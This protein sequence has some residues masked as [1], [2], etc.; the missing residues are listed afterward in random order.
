M[1]FVDSILYR[2][3]TKAD[4][5]NIEW[6]K[7]PSGGG[8]QTYIDLS[9]VD[10]EVIK[11]FFIDTAAEIDEEATKVD[12]EG[13]EWPAYKVPIRPL[14]HSEKEFINLDVRSAAKGIFRN[15]RIKN[16]AIT[17][18]RHIAWKPELGFPTIIGDRFQPGNN[19]SSADLD[20]AV[21]ELFTQL[22]IFIIKTKAGH[23]Y[24]G[25]ILDGVIPDGWPTDVGLEQIISKKGSGV[26]H[27][28]SLLEVNPNVSAE[29][30]LTVS[31]V[32]EYSQQSFFND[33]FMAEDSYRQI[34]SLLK[35]KKNII[36]QGSPGTGKT[37]AAKRIAYSLM[38]AKD[39]SC[40]C[41]V[42]FHQNSSYEDYVVGFRPNS[43]GEFR[44]TPGTFKKFFDEAGQRPEENFYLI[45]DEI[46]RANISKVFG[47]LL[48]AIEADHR[49][50]ILELPVGDDLQISVPPNVY[51]I[52]MMNTADRGLALIDYALRRRFAFVEMRPA[53]ELPNFEQ[54]IASK[55][56]PE[57]LSLV[58]AV[59]ELNAEIEEDPSLGSGFMIGHSYFCSPG[60]VDRET[61]KSI[62]EFELVPLI[63]EYWFDQPAL[64][65]QKI[66]TL[67]Q[68]IAV[69]DE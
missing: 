46:N 24:S 8:G 11:N 16:Q 4:F 18:N 22:V 31:E 13:F 45:I 62:V 34:V 25:F 68:A 48:M 40:I 5:L 69:S 9:G 49:G 27:P 50:E 33:V 32:K 35:R 20:P 60:S 39:D 38:G 47:E 41:S 37:F 63:R 42:Q 51:I 28:T 15:Y 12:A 58:K 19:Y 57:L 26:V 6:V 3:I 43:E 7:K 36:L 52:G 23:F 59:S 10:K 64:A 61:V 21:D 66:E 14:G 17:Q 30:A 56:S 65:T 53:L 44:P 55:G 54:F 2:H 29:S 1:Q 67:M